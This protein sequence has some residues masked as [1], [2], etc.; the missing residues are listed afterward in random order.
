MFLNIDFL[1]IF[2]F[3]SFFPVLCTPGFCI[4]LCIVSLLYTD[5]SLLFLNKFTDHYHQVQ[6]QWQ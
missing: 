3:V 6:T 5:V 1:K 2:L 4:V